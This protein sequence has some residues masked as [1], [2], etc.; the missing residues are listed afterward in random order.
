MKLEK[1]LLATNDI[2]FIFVRYW[3]AKT[4][5]FVPDSS[6]KQIVIYQHFVQDYAKI[7]NQYLSKSPPSRNTFYRVLY[8]TINKGGIQGGIFKQNNTLDVDFETLSEKWKPQSI[9]KF[10]GRYLNNIYFD[11]DKF[12]SPDFPSLIN[13]KYQNLLEIQLKFFSFDKTN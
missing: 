4:L 1:N 2:Q 9:R 11:T 10:E 6:I 5:I 8:E 7:N 12:W 3:I 13:V